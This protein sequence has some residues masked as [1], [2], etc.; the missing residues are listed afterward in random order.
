MRQPQSATITGPFVRGPTSGSYR[1]NL[2]RDYQRECFFGERGSWGYGPD[3]GCRK[4]DSVLQQYAWVAHASRVL[5]IASR[6]RGLSLTVKIGSAICIVRKDCFGETPKP[7][8]ERRA[9]PRRMQ[10][11]VILISKSRSTPAPRNRPDQIPPVRHRTGQRPD[12][13]HHTGAK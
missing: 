3:K 10:Q 4:S 5:A 13:G 9:L 1:T 8:R 6:N 7:T 2:N 12:I 11:H